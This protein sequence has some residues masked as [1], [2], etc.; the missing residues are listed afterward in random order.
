MSFPR[1]FGGY[2]CGRDW[3]TIPRVRRLACHERNP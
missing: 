1:S 2:D 3:A